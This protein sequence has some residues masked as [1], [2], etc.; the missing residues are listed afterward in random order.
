MTKY[1]SILAAALLA[2]TPALAQD[3]MMG[4]YDTDGDSMLNEMEF[5]EADGRMRF[6]D[7]DTDQSGDVSE[8]EFRAGEL[9]RYDRDGDSMINED[10]YGR[11]SEDRMDS[12]ED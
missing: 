10:E 12:E 2:A 3:G 8:E 4:D 6:M 1:A 7:Y 9:R 5:G 11:Y